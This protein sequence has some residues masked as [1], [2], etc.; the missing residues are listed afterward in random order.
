MYTETITFDLN[1]VSPI[2][3]IKLR[4]GENGLTNIVANFISNG[5]P[6]NLT[7]CTVNFCALNAKRAFTKRQAALTNAAQGIAT[8]TLTSDTTSVKGELLA[9]YFEIKNGDKIV[10]TGNIPIIIL[11]NVDISDEQAAEYKSTLDQM[12]SDVEEYY[13]K[14]KDVTDAANTATSKANTAASSANTAASSANS[15]A[16]SATSAAT[17]ANNAAKSAND[18]ADKVTKAMESFKTLVSTT[19]AYQISDTLNTGGSWSTSRPTVGQGQ[20]LWT[21][22]T[23]TF[24]TGDPQVFYIP[25][26]QGKDSDTKLQPQ[27]TDLDT[28]L[29]SLQTAWDSASLSTSHPITDEVKVTGAWRCTYCTVFITK[30]NIA[31]Y[32]IQMTT[33]SDIKIQNYSFNEFIPERYRPRSYAGLASTYGT[34]YINSSGSLIFRPTEEKSNGSVYLFGMGILLQGQ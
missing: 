8:Y 18:A 24:N 2:N 1:K 26:Y 30:S 31:N 12:M 25:S 16:S 23:Q 27:I 13:N 28:R 10:T 32:V 21:R 20:T 19:F 29:K 5:S 34:G 6:Y 3:P 11:D 7:G 33:D 17:S 4:R 22:V 14:V 15:A 9:A